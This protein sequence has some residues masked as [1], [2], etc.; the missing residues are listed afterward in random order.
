MTYPDLVRRWH[1]ESNTLVLLAVADELALSW[2]RADA[3]RRR[4]RT[5]A[6]HEPDLD[7]ALTAIALEPAA[8]RLV[9]HLPLALAAKPPP[10]T[11]PP[12]PPGPVDP[13]RA[14]QTVRREVKT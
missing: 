8:W 2:L 1:S 5:V 3:V 10:A 11:D 9:A 13:S 4:L 12:A 7:G 6:F 14:A